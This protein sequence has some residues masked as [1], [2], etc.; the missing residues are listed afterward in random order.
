MPSSR[1]FSWSRD[2]THVSCIS[3]RFFTTEPPG[4]PVKMRNMAGTQLWDSIVV[5]SPTNSTK[6]DLP[7]HSFPIAC[8]RGLS[9]GRGEEVSNHITMWILKTD[10]P[11]ETCHSGHQG[12]TWLR[13]SQGTHVGWVLEWMIHGLMTT[14]QLDGVMHLYHC[15]RNLSVTYYVHLI[16]KVI[17]A[18]TGGKGLPLFEPLMYH[19]HGPCE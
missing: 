19:F 12:E 14:V 2:R 18:Y 13:G 16:R 8:A 5:K 1:G 11:S 17:C 3:G 15:W 7:C 10:K 9:T 4:K 6:F